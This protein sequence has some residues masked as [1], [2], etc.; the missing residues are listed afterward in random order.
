MGGLAV[1]LWE[2]DSLPGKWKFWGDTTGQRN[3]TTKLII[4][5]DMFFETVELLKTL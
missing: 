2:P 5:E 4:V 1:G 3:T